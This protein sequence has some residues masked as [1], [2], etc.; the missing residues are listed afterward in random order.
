MKFLI[1][2]FKKIEIFE[3]YIVDLSAKLRCY[4]PVRQSSARECVITAEGVITIWFLHQ[5]KLSWNV[6]FL[7]SNEINKFLHEVW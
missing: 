5:E 1:F 6:K 3:I 2:F 7:L 4:F